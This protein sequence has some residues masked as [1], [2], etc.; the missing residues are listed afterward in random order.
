MSA[1]NNAKRPYD[2]VI[3]QDSEMENISLSD[4]NAQGAVCFPVQ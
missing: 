2:T 1:R 3:F 4:V